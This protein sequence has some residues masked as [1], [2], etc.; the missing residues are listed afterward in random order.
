MAEAE[1]NE[2]MWKDVCKL[3]VLNL[4]KMASHFYA[5]NVDS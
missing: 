3:P 2:Q 5:Q 1:M 4:V